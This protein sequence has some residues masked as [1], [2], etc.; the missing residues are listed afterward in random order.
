MTGP[1]YVECIWFGTKEIHNDLSISFYPETDVLGNI[2]GGDRGTSPQWPEHWYWDPIMIAGQPAAIETFNVDISCELA[3]GLSA[4]QG[5]NIR[6]QSNANACPM[7]QAVAEA[8]VKN[9]AG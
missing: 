2:Y 6:V 3:I 7:A 8:I 5:I 1:G 9:L 4:R